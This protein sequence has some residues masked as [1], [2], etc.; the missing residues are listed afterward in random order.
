MTDD[1]ILDL[2]ALVGGLLGLWWLLALG[3]VLGSALGAGR[4]GYI[5]GYWEATAVVADITS[6]QRAIAR[7]VGLREDMEGDVARYRLSGDERVGVLL[8]RRL[9]TVRAGWEEHRK[10]RLEEMAAAAGS[11]GIPASQLYGRY[12]APMPWSVG[13]VRVEYVGA[14]LAR[15]I[16]TWSIVGLA[17]AVLL[18]IL[19]VVWREE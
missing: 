13:P 12:A 18:S 4:A 15:E 9:E 17:G 11:L 2:R 6:G 14:P 10:A 16:L 1:R 5:G 8:V 19:I 7:A 3:L